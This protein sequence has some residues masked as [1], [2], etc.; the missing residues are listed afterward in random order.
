[1]S[2]HMDRGLWPQS[3]ASSPAEGE[4]LPHPATRVL[5]EQLCND[6]AEKSLSI[7]PLTVSEHLPVD[8]TFFFF[9]CQLS[10]D[11]KTWNYSFC[12]FPE[13][14]KQNNKIQRG[15]W[16]C[17]PQSFAKRAGEEYLNNSID[18]WCSRTQ[19]QP[20]RCRET[21]GSAFTFPEIAWRG[22]LRF[23]WMGQR[24]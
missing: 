5:S 11:L 8:T 1:M 15:L 4:P 3:S 23:I 17:C 10:P 9:F 2:W 21:Q 13:G 19:A 16:A 24:H 14:K 7:H 22:L 18:D 6:I 12:L 20:H